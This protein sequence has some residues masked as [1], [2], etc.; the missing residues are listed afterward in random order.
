MT[1][2]L[3]TT[4]QN[5]RT[6]LLEQI[7]GLSSIPS[8]EAIVQPLIGYLQQPIE[9]LDMQRVVD[10]ISHDN[11]LAAQCLHLANSPLFG[12]WQAITTTRA[13]VIALGLQRMRDVAVSCCVLKLL[14]SGLSDKN[15]VV[16]WEHS[17]ACALVCRRIAKRIGMKDPEQAYLC[18]LLHDLGFIVN[19][20]LVGD[21]V[22]DV[23]K[24]AK[25]RSCPIEAIEEEHFGFNHCETGRILARKW[26]LASE[27]IEVISYHHRLSVLADYPSLI[28]LVNIGD[29][30][31]RLHGLGHGFPE[32][33]PIDWNQDASVEILRQAWPIAK[34][35]NWEQFSGELDSYLQDVHKLVSV[36]YR[37]TT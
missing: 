5:R 1:I 3:H 31:C 17:L 20:H 12:R 22:F 13:A 4:I 36:L 19:L 21:E 8:V 2:Q 28:S 27:I 33:F 25:L 32:E 18:G 6:S 10:L 24:D 9:S 11:S 14:P 7:D 34:N 16:F 23:V 30:L 37:F 29:R 26:G 15:P 35:V